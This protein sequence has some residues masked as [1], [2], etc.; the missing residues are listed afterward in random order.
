MGGKLAAC[1]QNGPL[2]RKGAMSANEPGL[3]SAD[4]SCPR[5]IPVPPDLRPFAEELM[6]HKSSRPLCV[7]GVVPCRYQNTMKYWSDGYQLSVEGSAGV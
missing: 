2:G 6:L 5:W 3:L 1:A 4:E 7:S